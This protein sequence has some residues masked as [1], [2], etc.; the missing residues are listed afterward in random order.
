[1]MAS[2]LVSKGG[3][4]S[5]GAGLG[6]GLGISIGTKSVF[7]RIVMILLGKQESKLN[8]SST[9]TENNY[10]LHEVHADNLTQTFLHK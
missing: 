5:R 9:Q 3:Y 10:K 8:G 7:S 1:M 4:F 6:S 2:S